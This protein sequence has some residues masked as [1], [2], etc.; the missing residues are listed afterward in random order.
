MGKTAILGDKFAELLLLW[1]RVAVELTERKLCSKVKHSRAH[2]L[3]RSSEE[4]DKT[5]KEI[6][7]HTHVLKHTHTHLNM[8][9]N[10]GGPQSADKHLQVF[11]KLSHTS[12]TY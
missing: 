8:K 9:V 1:R 5:D 3:L 4:M 2:T 10:A 11:H 7:T 12:T 6:T